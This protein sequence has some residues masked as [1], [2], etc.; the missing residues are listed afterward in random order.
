MCRKNSNAKPTSFD[1]EQFSKRIIFSLIEICIFSF[2]AFSDKGIALFLS[3]TSSGH[4]VVTEQ[5]LQR[6]IFSLIGI[7]FWH[8]PA[9]GLLCFLSR[10]PHAA[11]ISEVA[12]MHDSPKQVPAQT[13]SSKFLRRNYGYLFFPFSAVSQNLVK[14]NKSKLN[15]KHIQQKLQYIDDFNTFVHFN[16]ATYRTETRSLRKCVSLSGLKS[17]QQILPQHTLS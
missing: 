8:L 9:P 3:L 14:S 16:H 7:C 17:S 11:W 12:L 6:I 13:A 1:T 2:P 15:I 4:C 10:H 5:F